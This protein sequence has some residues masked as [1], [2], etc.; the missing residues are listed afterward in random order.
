M[1]T[2]TNIQS[3]YAGKAAG[4]IIGQSFKEGETLSKGL[5]RVYEN[6]NFKLNLRKIDYTDGTTPYSCGF[7]PSGDIDLS[8]KV[9]R[10]FKIQK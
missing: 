4:D 2:T 10:A 5:V 1:P 7:S 8:E 9:F 6:I 3:F